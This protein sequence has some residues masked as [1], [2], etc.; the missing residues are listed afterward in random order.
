MEDIKL[1]DIMWGKGWGCNGAT[2]ETGNLA[3]IKK[4]QLK[5]TNKIKRHQENVQ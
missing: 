3:H 2:E 4:N 5:T 1:Q